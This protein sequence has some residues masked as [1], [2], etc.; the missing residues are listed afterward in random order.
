MEVP[1]KIYPICCYNIEV[2]IVYIRM[3][4]NG[5]STPELEVASMSF[6]N[7]KRGL[8][9][10][11][12]PGQLIILIF[13]LIFVCILTDILCLLLLL[14]FLLLMCICL[15]LHNKALC[16]SVTL[17]CNTDYHTHLTL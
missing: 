7:L 5:V 10:A 17:L 8:G 14:L 13:Y 16:Y 1:T 15:P 2:T 12:A 6:D 3:G 4:G 11:L 9:S